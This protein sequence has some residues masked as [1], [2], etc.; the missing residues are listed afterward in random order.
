MLRRS[1]PLLLAAVAICLFASQPALAEDKSHEGMIVSAG[2]GKLSMMMT[3]DTKTHTHDVAKNAKIMLDG[4]AAKLEDLKEHFHVKVTTDD[5]NVATSIEA[6]S[7]A[8]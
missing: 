6:H 4:K 8:K 2:A 5:K 3:G 7:K 1:I